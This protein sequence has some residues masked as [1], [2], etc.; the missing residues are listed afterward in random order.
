MSRIQHILDKAERDGGLLRMRS[1]DADVPIDK[2]EV[3]E[4]PFAAPE[5]LVTTALAPGRVVQDTRL[6]PLLVAA[7]SPGARASEQYRALRMRVA[8]ADHASPARVLLV[9]S[10]GRREGKTVT[11][12]NLALTMAQDFQRRVCVVDADLR[13]S[14]LHRLFGLADGPG[15]T[16]VLTGRTE[17][18][19]ALTLLED[20]QMT[21]LPA[22]SATAHPAELLGGAAMRD[23]I[24]RLRTNFDRVIIDAPAAAPL[25]D[26][27]ILAPLADRAVLVVRAGQTTKPAIQEAVAIIGSDRLLG[28]VLNDSA[29]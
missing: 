16:D 25:A 4:H 5:V 28:I 21:L 27:G 19:D 11:A 8:H 24:E 2:P 14:R 1:V 26:L 18:G 7:H 12:A 17:L 15:L 9:T 23:A 10:P 6:D 13:H 29:N 3:A 22:G 20:Q